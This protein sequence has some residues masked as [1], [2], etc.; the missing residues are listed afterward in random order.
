MDENW[1]SNQLCGHESQESYSVVLGKGFEIQGQDIRHAFCS[2]GSELLIDGNSLI[3]IHGALPFSPQG[4]TVLA[5]LY[6][7][8]SS[9][10]ISPLM[11]IDQRFEVVFFRGG[12]HATSRSALGSGTTGITVLPCSETLENRKHVLAI[13]DS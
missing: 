9:E 2:D 12:C 7:L 10:G 8:Q 5:I 3:R 13:A 11:W 4:L 1:D 6:S